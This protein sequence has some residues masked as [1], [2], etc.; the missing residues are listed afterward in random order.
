MNDFKRRHQWYLKEHPDFD[1]TDMSDV[2]DFQTQYCNRAAAFGM[3]SCYF[4]EAGK[5][6]TGFDGKF[7][8]HTWSAPGFN[9]PEEQPAPTQEE[10]KQGDIPVNPVQQPPVYKSSSSITH[11]MC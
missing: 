3:K 7:G 5:S 11:K 6:G 1:P 8:E 2:K 9:T 10:T 4:L